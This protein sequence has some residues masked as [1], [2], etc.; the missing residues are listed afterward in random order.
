MTIDLVPVDQAEEPKTEQD[1]SPEQPPEDPPEPENQEQPEEPEPEEP[2]AP[3]KRGRPAGSKN[4][5]KPPSSP[6]EEVEEPAPQP[7]KIARVQSQPLPKIPQPS[8][9]QTVPFDQILRQ[10]MIDVQAR[11][12]EEKTARQAQYTEMLQKRCVFNKWS[13]CKFGTSP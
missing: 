3:K 12:L 9:T 2:P 7:K 6:P 5:P 1:D 13:H 8:V 10:R 11:A 4:K